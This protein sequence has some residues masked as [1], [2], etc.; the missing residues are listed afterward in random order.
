MS[1]DISA[2]DSFFDDDDELEQTNI[3]FYGTGSLYNQIL[4]IFDTLGGYK[5]HFLKDQEEISMSLLQNNFALAIIEMTGTTEETITLTNLVRGSQPITRIILMTNSISMDEFSIIMNGGSVD[6]LHEVPINKAELTSIIIDNDARYMIAYSVTNLVSDPPELSKASF[7]LL[8]PSLEYADENIPLNFVGI[9]ITS[10]T[11][12]QYTVWF[13]ET[14]AQDEFLLAGYLSS[15]SLL[16]D[17][18]FKNEQALKEINFGGISVLFRFYE[19]CQFSFFVRNL[20]RR[21]IEKAEQRITKVVDNIVQDFAPQLIERRL[22]DEIYHNLNL[23]TAEFEAVDEEE[24]KEYE[25]IMLKEQVVK[26]HVVL[27]FLKD[28][29][30][31]DVLLQE[32]TELKTREQFNLDY[33][34][35]SASTEAEVIQKLNTLQCSVLIIDSLREE[36]EKDIAAQS[37]L[38]SETSLLMQ[39]ILLE[40][41]QITSPKFSITINQGRFNY[42]SNYYVPTVNIFGT[43]K[44]ALLKT[45]R[46]QKQAAL[47]KVKAGSNLNVAKSILRDNLE[48]FDAS[49]KPELQGILI[50]KE[51]QPKFQIFWE[52]DGEKFDFDTSMLAGLITSLKSVGDEMF[53]ESEEISLLEIVGSNV[54]IDNYEKYF[55]IYF[56]KNLT[57]E[58]TPV[59]EKELKMVSQVYKEV[60]A[61]AHDIIPIEQLEQLF[62][63]L[64]NKA[65]KDFTQLLASKD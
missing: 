15:I 33:S 42:V 46:D 52:V 9:M 21:N 49:T 37:T 43:I 4:S 58:V 29:S 31:L 41:D 57:T 54:F 13:E 14:L 20:N 55:I 10:A 51:L 8:D 16:G 48:S 50:S 30:R 36:S 39:Q 44:E 26:E 17:D 11:V 61:E 22:T 28:S 19:N 5:V 62:A 1:D 40:R 24:I 59:I 47:G 18:L 65:H 12:P 60:I 7:L 64:A 45:D 63:K 35:Q 2:L 6:G 53:T 3:M 56:V 27:L 25:D 32:L 38:F 34:F 23:I